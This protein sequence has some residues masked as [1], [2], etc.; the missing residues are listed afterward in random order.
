MLVI[1]YVYGIP[2]SDAAAAVPVPGAQ[3][4]GAT[5]VAQCV[6]LVADLHVLVHMYSY[7]QKLLLFI[8]LLDHIIR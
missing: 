2:F 4:A 7:C 1:R 6:V 5:Y 3:L 8:H